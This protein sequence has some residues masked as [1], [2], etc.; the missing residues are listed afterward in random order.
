MRMRM[1]AARRAGRGDG[2]Q[3]HWIQ[4]LVENIFLQSFIVYL[5]IYL[6]RNKNLKKYEDTVPNREK[7]NEHCESESKDNHSNFNDKVTARNIFK[8]QCEGNGNN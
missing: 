2:A 1:R 8:D 6:F 5:F 4:M 3:S 7:Q